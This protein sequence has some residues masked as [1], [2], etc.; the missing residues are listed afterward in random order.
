MSLLLWPQG[1]PGALGEEAEDKPTL[2]P[3]LAEGPGVKP[4]VIVCPGGGYARRAAHE[5]D[6]VALW[7]N[8]LGISAFVVHYRVAPY[9]HPHPLSDAQRAIRTVRHRAAEWNID[10]ARVG[11]LGFSAGGHLASSAG[12]HY[13]AGNPESADPVERQSCRPDLLVLCYPVITFGPYTHEGSKMNLLGEGAPEELVTLMSSER[14]VNEN[15][16]PTFLW[17]TADDGAVP[18]ENALFF[19]SALSRSKVP[20]ELHVYESGRHGLGLAEDHPEAHTWTQLCGT[21]LKKQGF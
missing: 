21:W 5:G 3:Y 11:I 15:T 12:T 9:Q 18:V 19:A 2:V 17:H 20:F 14:Q 4:A 16:P 10:P 8:G 1:T 6:P 7:L 13:D